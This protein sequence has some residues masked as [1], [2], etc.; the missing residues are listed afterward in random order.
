MKNL[1]NQAA[2][3]IKLRLI[4]RR[5]AVAI[6]VALSAPVL[7]GM[8]GLVTDVTY[9]YGSRQAMQLAADAGAMAAA[10]SGQ[11]TQAT[12][13]TIAINAAN[14]STDGKYNFNANNLAVTLTNGGASFKT[15]S[16]T[17]SV[18]S[19]ST[20]ST[21][22]STVTVVAKTPA[23]I[24][25]SGIL[26]V[27]HGALAASASST[28]RQNIQ[29]PNNS[30]LL[31]LTG[32]TGPTFH[33]GGLNFVPNDQINQ[34]FT[35][36]GLNQGASGQLQS[37][38]ASYISNNNNNVNSGST[39]ALNSSKAPPC[40]TLLA[41]LNA[42]TLNQGSGQTLTTK[43][44]TSTSWS[45][46]DGGSVTVY[47]GAGTTITSTYHPA[48]YYVPGYGTFTKDQC[49]QINAYYGDGTCKYQKAYYSYSVPTTIDPN[50]GSTVP[51]WSPV[52]VTPTTQVDGSLYCA[53][54]GA[55]TPSATCDIPAAAYCGG[56]TINPGSTIDFTQTGGDGQA[57]MILDGNAIIP[58]SAAPTLVAYTQTDPQYS[59]NFG[60]SYVGG[61]LN[62][63]Q[64]TIYPGEIQQGTVVYNTTET[65]TL[66]SG[67][68][69]YVDQVCPAGVL[70]DGL[71]SNSNA[72]C[73]GI[74][75]T[76]ANGVTNTSTVGTGNSAGTATNSGPCPQGDT[77][78]ANGG[79]SFSASADN[80]VT[81]VDTYITSVY[82]VSGVPT[83]AQVSEKSYYC[84]GTTCSPDQASGNLY[85]VTGQNIN[86]NNTAPPPTTAQLTCSASASNNLYNATTAANEGF[87]TSTS[88]A[89][90]NDSVQVCGSGPKLVAIASNGTILVSAVNSSNL[91]MS[92]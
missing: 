3:A 80:P 66:Y 56:L 83:Y 57:F 85:L 92:D 43:T 65:Q 26:G 18:P 91:W 72:Q 54:N 68:Y 79:L 14:L 22:F 89:T 70:P 50:S 6:M 19:S 87:S 33:V 8:A 4:R 58:N 82:F 13:Q 11:T 44:I 61:L 12:L 28:L 27:P 20:S 60:G 88:Y 67:S 42:A 51:E 30:T 32:N 69:Y 75:Q 10:R 47:F 46:G 31:S 55:N 38:S 16:G 35:S 2:C 17:Q 77:C 40:T 7:L 41:K 90:Q 36:V 74:T 5:A 34:N 86:P 71:T 63:T 76:T 81:F 78:G 48:K 62:T 23:P 29:P 53:P 9:W 21:S 37:G 73:A 49:D 25:F 59:F 84:Y 39:G 24:F 45:N 15:P 52:V 1:L 64:T